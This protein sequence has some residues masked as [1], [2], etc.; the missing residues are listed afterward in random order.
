MESD[1]QQ[2]EE[3]KRW[4]AENGRAVVLGVVLGLGSVGGYLGW[5]RYTAAQA[6]TAS[7]LYSR[8]V[9]TQALQN[10]SAVVTQADELI[11]EFP[12]SAYS[13]LAGLVAA[14]SAYAG[15][16]VDNTVRL[17]QWAESHAPEPEVSH[18]ARLR[19]ARVLAEKE[20]FDAALSALDRIDSKSFSDLAIETRGDVLIAKGDADA[21]RASYDELLSSTT[22]DSRGR[23]RVQA[24]LDELG[25]SGS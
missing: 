25:A 8:M 1:D 17:L 4:W 14:S 23:A 24:K 20:S 3:L 19:L 11:A 2:I 12:D 21:A 16:D 5:Q 15:G 13:A 22:L 7:T 10:H 9:N 6:E 18:V